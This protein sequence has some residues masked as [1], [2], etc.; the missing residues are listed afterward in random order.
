MTTKE[1][2][3][4]L[5]NGGNIHTRWKIG[6]DGLPGFTTVVRSSHSPG[7][8]LCIE[9]DSSESTIDGCYIDAHT[10]LTDH[11]LPGFA[12]IGRSYYPIDACLLYTSPSPRDS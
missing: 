1:I 5:D 9:S 2:I 7:V 10:A 12:I 11:S 4:H 6:I 8:R 3:T